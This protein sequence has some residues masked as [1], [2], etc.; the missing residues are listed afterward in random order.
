MYSIDQ[1]KCM[2]CGICVTV[3]PEGIKMIR[4]KAKIKN[5]DVTCLDEAA[6]VCPVNI[7]VNNK[8]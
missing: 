2:G 5:H 7:I 8:K 6:E 3:C 1:N 4:G